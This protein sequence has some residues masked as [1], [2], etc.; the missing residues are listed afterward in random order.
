M[1]PLVNT[2]WFDIGVQLLDPKY[3]NELNTIEAD[4]KH[5]AATCCR[6]M[7]CKWLNS[8]GLA[9]WKKLMKAL[10]MVQMHYVA[11][12]IEKLLLQGELLI[13]VHCICGVKD[14]RMMSM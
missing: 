9:N 14:F 7:F 8:D 6:K 10:R 13:H 11:D 2:K 1:I 3:E 12:D 4:T 5:D